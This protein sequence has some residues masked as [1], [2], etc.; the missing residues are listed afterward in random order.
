MQHLDAAWGSVKVEEQAGVQLAYLYSHGLAVIDVL[1]YA[2]WVRSLA[3][4]AH[5]A[6][7]VADG[8]PDLRKA[9]VALVVRGEATVASREKMR[10]QLLREQADGVRHR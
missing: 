10:E 5:W 3:T 2:L 4:R 6:V 8:W 7:K 1:D 9:D